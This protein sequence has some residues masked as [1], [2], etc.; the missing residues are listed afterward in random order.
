MYKVF[1]KDSC[2]FLT[3]Q[4]NFNRETTF[5]LNHRDSRTTREFI[6][7]LLDH[8]GPFTA[9]IFHDDVEELFS[10]FKSCFTCVQAAGGVVRQDGC[11]LVIKRLGMYDLPK[12]HRESDETIEQCA[13]REV[14]EECGLKEVQITAPIDSTLHIY[15][16]DNQWHLKK[17]YWYVMS[18][19]PHSEPTPQT[20]EDIEEVFWLPISGIDSIL[21]ETYASLRSI[22]E[23]I[24]RISG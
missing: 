10:V 15:P 23:T 4:T 21:P 9:A 11:L 7:Q 14:E 2:F 19:P 12:G 20:E 17:T 16:R 8:P 3:E 18:C 24:R 22:F 1:F 5:S 6:L 13:V